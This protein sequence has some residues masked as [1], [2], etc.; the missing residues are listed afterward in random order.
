MEEFKINNYIT[1]RLESGKTNI[2]IK[3]E[4]FNQCKSLLLSLSREE[5]EALKRIESLDEVLEIGFS[6]EESIEEYIEPENRELIDS[7]TPETEFWAH[8]SN[9]QVWKEQ[10]YDTQLIHSNFIDTKEKKKYC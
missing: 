9:L 8:C 6:L 5:L 3:G 2:Y 7:I 4:L 1:L 10:E